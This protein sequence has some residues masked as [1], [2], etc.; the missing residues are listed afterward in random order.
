M[1]NNLFL[2]QLRELSLEEGK[3]YIQ[4][5]AAEI[6]EDGAVGKMLADEGRSLLYIRFVSLKLAE[7][8]I[9]CGD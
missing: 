8:F 6:E 1:D 3:A 9:L 4:E 5:H 2:E 7:V